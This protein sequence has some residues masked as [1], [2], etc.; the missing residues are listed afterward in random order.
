MKIPKV[1]IYLSI[2]SI[3]LS[4]AY[5]QAHGPSVR[6]ISVVSRV[7]HASAGFFDI[8]LPLDGRPGIECRNVA[9]GNYTLVLTFP[10][11]ISF[12]DAVLTTAG[13]AFTGGIAST[14]IDSSQKILT[15]NLANVSD[16]Q[17]IKITIHSL[18]H[19]GP[20]G[21]SQ[22]DLSV[23]MGILVGDVDGSGSITTSDTASIT[24]QLGNVVNANNFRNDVNADGTI[25]SSDKT[26]A[27]NRANNTLNYTSFSFTLDGSYST[28]AGV[29]KNGRLIRTLWSSVFYPAGT[30]S[31]TWDGTDDYG[32]EGRR[33][34]I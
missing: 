3:G 7:N 10:E 25:T 21:P 6:P 11:T 29:F 24:G 31:S 5:G 14:S 19:E 1:S 4:S 13:G 17:T 32:I 33:G 23:A 26:L 2:I 12:T 20:N 22:N 9:D 34:L 8:D 15:I 18:R 30:Y 27:R 16:Q 28:S